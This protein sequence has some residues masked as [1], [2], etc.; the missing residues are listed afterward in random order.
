MRR[1]PHGYDRPGR[2]TALAAVVFV[3]PVAVAGFSHWS[4]RAAT[5]RA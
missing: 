3:I 4:A 2:L 5:T 1:G